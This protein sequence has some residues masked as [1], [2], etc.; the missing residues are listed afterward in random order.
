MA[1]KSKR[2]RGKTES[3]GWKVLRAISHP[4]R[5]E[6][7]RILFNRIATPKEIAKELGEELSVISYHVLDLKG[8]GCIGWV[9]QLYAAVPFEVEDVVADHAQ[10]LPELFAISFG[11]AI[12][13]RMRWTSMRIGWEIARSTFQPIDSCLPLP[14]LDL[15]AIDRPFSKV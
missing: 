12:Q 3:I 9:R 15:A 2:G 5:I 7:Q 13:K 1:A 11:V 4:I 10:P 8:D 6:V 14:R